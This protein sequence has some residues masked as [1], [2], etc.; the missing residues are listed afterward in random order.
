[1]TVDGRATGGRFTLLPPASFCANP[2]KRVPLRTI[3]EARAACPDWAI[4]KEERTLSPLPGDPHTRYFFV[5]NSALIS[6]YISE[7]VF[8]G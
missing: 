8:Y 6:R 1:M 4:S 3:V 5:R 2:K 7:N